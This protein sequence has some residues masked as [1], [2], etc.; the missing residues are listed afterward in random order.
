MPIISFFAKISDS[1]K[2]DMLARQTFPNSWKFAVEEYKDATSVPY[3]CLR[4]VMDLKLDQYNRYRLRTN[5]FPGEQQ[6]VYVQK[7][8]VESCTKS[9]WS[10]A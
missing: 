10:S 7:W 4:V 6:F 1:S 8:K 2:F 9:T 3:G 5:I